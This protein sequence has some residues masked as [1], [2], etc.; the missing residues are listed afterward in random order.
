MQGAV[1]Q[2]FLLR[3]KQCFYTDVLT[4]LML[5]RHGIVARLINNQYQKEVDK[6]EAL[7]TSAEVVEPV[8]MGITEHCMLTEKTYQPDNYPQYN[9]YM[10]QEQIRH[11]L[12]KKAKAVID[13]LFL[14]L[15]QWNVRQL[16]TLQTPLSPRI[17]L[18]LAE[19]FSKHL[20]RLINQL[21]NNHQFES[22]IQRITL[23]TIYGHENIMSIFK[24]LQFGEIVPPE[25]KPPVKKEPERERIVQIRRLPPK[26]DGPG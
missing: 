1:Y 23:Y 22:E 7:H 25:K 4:E 17:V 2:L 26:S 5:P 12:Q 18:K 6:H 24:I 13:H 20:R 10:W 19:H 9:Q 14:E 16:T 3:L 15:T 8:I 21:G 11:E